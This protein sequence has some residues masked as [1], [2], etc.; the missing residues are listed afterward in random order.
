MY[1]TDKLMK[2]RKQAI[3]THSSFTR[4]PWINVQILLLENYIVKKNSLAFEAK[5]Y[6]M[7][8]NSST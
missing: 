6:K 8:E 3:Q 7:E 2:E 1:Q 5:Q 4:F